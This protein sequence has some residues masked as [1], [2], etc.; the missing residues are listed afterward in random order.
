MYL[1]LSN[2]SEQQSESGS[3]SLFGDDPSFSYNFR[4]LQGSETPTKHA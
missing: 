2:D 4:I 1:V 3:N